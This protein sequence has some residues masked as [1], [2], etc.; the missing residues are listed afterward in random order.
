MRKISLGKL[1]QMI[2]HALLFHVLYDRNDYLQ[3][4]SP[5]RTQS[6]IVFRN[7]WT[8]YVE[9]AFHTLGGTT[10][11]VSSY[12]ISLQFSTLKIIRVQVFDCCKTSLSFPDVIRLWWT[13]AKNI[14]HVKE[15]LHETKFDL[16]PPWLE[17][18]AFHEGFYLC[19]TSCSFQTLA[20]FSLFNGNNIMDI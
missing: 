13:R 18:T 9:S 7:M 5:K 1:H 16:T 2:N 6:L 15:Q 12:H 8:A 11:C 19:T 3:S 17:L 10:P 4:S 14:S 20:L